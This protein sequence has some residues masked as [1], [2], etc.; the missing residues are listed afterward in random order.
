MMMKYKSDP[1]S[2]LLKLRGQMETQVDDDLIKACY[3]LQSDHQYDKDRDTINRMKAL[4]EDA[5][6]S[7]A[8]DDIL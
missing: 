2:V 5:V 4:V 1:L 8:R 3:K 7:N 6:V